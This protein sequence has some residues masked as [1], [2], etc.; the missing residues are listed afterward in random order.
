MS[1][2]KRDPL[3]PPRI[4]TGPNRFNHYHDAFW[5]I[6]TGLVF[7]GGVVMAWHALQSIDPGHLYCGIVLIGAAVLMG[8]AE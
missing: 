1:G 8:T 2:L 5:V 3:L 6:F 7:L 4:D